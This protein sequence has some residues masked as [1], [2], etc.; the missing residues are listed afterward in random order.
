M[1]INKIIEKAMEND[2][3]GLQEAFAEEMS[4][5]IQ[6][7]LEEKYK[8][9]NKNE[10][11]DDEPDCSHCEGVGYHEDEDGNKVDCSKCDGS[12]KSGKSHDDDDD[13]DDDDEELDD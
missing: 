9:M 1:S 10:A 5:R 2:P 4:E 6:T 8:K 3:M 12:G 11:S 13:D 7:A